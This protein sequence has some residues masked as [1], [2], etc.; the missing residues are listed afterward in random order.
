MIVALSASSPIT[1]VALIGEDGDELFAGRRESAQNA[2]GVC[3]ELLGL[4]LHSTGLRI[5][6][7]SLFVADL[8]PG[9]F[10]GVRVGVTFVKTLGFSSDKPVAGVSSFD[11]IDR[12]NKVVV[13]CKKGEFFLRSPCR[14]AIR[15]TGL[16]DDLGIVGYGQG[17]E[18]QVYPDAVRVASLLDKLAPM[19]AE[20]LTPQYL[21]EPSISIPKKPYAQQV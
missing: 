5:A 9:S 8:G 14:Q 7:A 3:A 1:S 2:S 17:I 4:G 11:L 13:P 19:R 12:L 6:D 20:L 10:I 15:L 21:I 18:K 16:P